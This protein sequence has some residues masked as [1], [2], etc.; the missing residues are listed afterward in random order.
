[1]PFLSSVVHIYICMYIC[2][3][4]EKNRRR[5]AG[6]YPIIYSFKTNKEGR[7][8][9]RREVIIFGDGVAHISFQV[10]TK[11]GKNVGH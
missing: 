10:G 7:R 3:L 11:G 4:G 9:R 8:T 5:C 2:T 6:R 1:M